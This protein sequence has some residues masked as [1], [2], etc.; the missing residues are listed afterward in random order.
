MTKAFVR[1]V[2]FP[3][4]RRGILS[5]STPVTLT[6]SDCELLIQIGERQSILPVIWYGVKDLDL[7]GDWSDKFKERCLKDI[8]R[9]AN[10]DYIIEKVEQVLSD[11]GIAFVLLKGTVVKDFYPEEWIRTCYDVDILVHK[12]DV[13]HAV[14]LI[15]K[16][17]D[18]KVES[19]NYHDVSMF[20]NQ[21]S[22]ELH[23]SIKENMENIDTLL[24]RVW[25]Y[26]QPTGNGQLYKLT[27]EYQIFHIIAH[28]SYHMVHGGLGIRPFLDLWLLQNNI[29]YDKSIL[30]EMC[31]SCGILKF[32]EACCEILDVWMNAKEHTETTEMLELYCL[33]GGAFGSIQINAAAKQRKHQGISYLLRRLFINNKVSCEFQLEQNRNQH[34]TFFH[35][36]RRW[37]RLFNFKKIK[38]VMQEIKIINNSNKND[39]IL[40]DK[41]LTKLGL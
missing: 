35:H 2:F 13:A 7:P 19:Y 28:M 15:K 10:R 33:R 6:E 9:F 23:F 31:K 32:Y 30:N 3:V 40:F 38:Q 11:V 29:A 8:F 20:G 21:I 24:S 1:N 17:L 34:F 39:I 22:L 37:L 41:L 16:N 18:F 36:L 12:E 14:E 26:A 25:D 5:T 4:I 27:P